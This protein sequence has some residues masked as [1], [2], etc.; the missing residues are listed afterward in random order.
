MISVTQPPHDSAQPLLHKLFK[1]Q[2]QKSPGHAN[3]LKFH[4]R[5]DKQSLYQNKQ[6]WGFH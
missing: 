4:L 3:E 2:V 1:L 6:S 5:K